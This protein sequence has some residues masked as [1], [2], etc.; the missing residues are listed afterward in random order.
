MSKI[1]TLLNALN[2]ISGLEFV[3]DAWKDKAP[4]D[5]GVVELTGE[6]TA[7][8]ADNRMIDQMFRCTVHIYV[9]GGDMK[10]I[11]AVQDVLDGQDI[12]YQMPIREYL[13][14]DHMVHWSWNCR[15]YGP[16]AEAEEETTTD[17]PEAVN[18]GEG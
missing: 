6:Q 2:E 8:W 5:Y 12:W 3:L 14:D 4:A 16:I 11:S 18:D 15:I 9:N 1:D 17:D 10:W 13:Y 7:L